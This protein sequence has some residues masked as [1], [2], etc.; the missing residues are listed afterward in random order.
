MM[1]NDKDRPQRELAPDPSAVEDA[2]PQ[3]EEDEAEWNEEVR[4]E[5][6]RQDNPKLADAV[7][8]LEDL[9]GDKKEDASD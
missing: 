9:V 1:G 8:E 3:V 4:R 6:L 5:H 2:P 7:D